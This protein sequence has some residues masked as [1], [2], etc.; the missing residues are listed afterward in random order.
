MDKDI[1]LCK[2]AI[3]NYGLQC[4]YSGFQYVKQALC[5]SFGDYSNGKNKGII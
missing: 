5:G 1:G 4:R 3:C 2:R